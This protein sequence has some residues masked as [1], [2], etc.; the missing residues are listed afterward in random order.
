MGNP[1]TKNLLGLP[2]FHIDRG[3]IKIVHMNINMIDMDESNGAVEIVPREFSLP[4]RRPTNAWGGEY[5]P[6][7]EVD[8][9]CP[10]AKRMRGTGH[11]GTIPFYD[12]C[13]VLHRG[14]HDQTGKRL[15][16]FISFAPRSKFIM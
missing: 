12:S 6:D 15:I 9:L 3:A 5:F 16:F 7:T 4:F 8:P 10:T 2:N 11:A 14:A 1:G 13:H